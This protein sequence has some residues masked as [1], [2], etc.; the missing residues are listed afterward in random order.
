MDPA[1]S[2]FGQLIALYIGIGGMASGLAMMMGGTPW[3]K[4]TAWFF[5]IHPFA[6]L[7]GIKK[8][9]KKKKKK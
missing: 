4:K 1:A 2:L 5:F 6:L 9:K 7:L 3:L 8:K